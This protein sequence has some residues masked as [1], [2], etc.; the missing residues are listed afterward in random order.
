MERL[1]SY[2]LGAMHMEKNDILKKAAAVLIAGGIVAFPTETVFGLG[3]IFDNE[4]TYNK[5]NAIK[6][7][8][9][10][11][12]FTMMLAEVKDIE[13]YAYISDESQKLI[14]AFMPGPITLLMPTKSNVP[15]WVTHGSAKIGIRVSSEKDINKLIKLVGK[16]LLVPS[17]NKSGE[18]P[19]LNSFEAENIFGSEVDFYIEG[20]SGCKRPSTIVDTCGRI[21]IVREGDISLSEINKVLEEK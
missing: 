8:S 18:K 6:K 20:S 9:D 17:A 21:V 1:D 12:P 13:K 16:P 14:T 2:L 4:K 11:K 3:I 5:L 10:D 19:A 7:R 15:V